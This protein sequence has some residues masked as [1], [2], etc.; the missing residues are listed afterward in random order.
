VPETRGWKSEDARVSGRLLTR[1]ALTGVALYGGLDLAGA[2]GWLECA[3][4]AISRTKPLPVDVENDPA[5][6]WAAELEAMGVGR[7]CF[8]RHYRLL[9]ATDA[10][11]YQ[12]E[13]LGVVVADSAASLAR[14]VAWCGRN[15]V[16]LLVR[17]GG[18]SLAG[19]CV[20]RA[21]VV[22][23]SAA[24][25]RI[26]GL[27]GR[28]VHVEPGVI[29]DDL[30]RWL[31]PRGLF[32]APDPATSAQ[33]TVGGCVGNNAAG[34]R[35]IRYGRTSENVAAL[36]VALTDGRR[37]WLG[38]GAGRRDAA[39]L[40][41]AGRVIEV[42]RDHAD[43]IRRR[44]PK[45]SRRNSG[46][47]LDMV[48]EQLDRGAGT[49]DL[50]L[51]PLIC[52]S[53][54]TLAAV[55]GAKL[56]LREIPRFKGLAIVSFASVGAALDTLSAVLDTQPTAVELLDDAVLRA[57]GGNIECQRY[58]ALVP[59]GSAA[60]AVLYVEYQDAQSAG[61][62]QAGFE[63]LAAALPD[64][65]MATYVQP[66][67]LADA[68][69]LRKAGEPLLHGLSAQRKPVTFIE[70]NAVPAHNLARFV[71]GLRQII[72]RHGTSAAYYA[73]ASVGVLHVRP[74]L[75]LH[76]PSDRA[77]MQAIAVEA[78]ELARQCGGMISGEHGDGRA[79]GPLLEQYFG[80]QLMSAFE[81]IKAI[82]DPAGVL[83]PGMT[84]RPGPVGSIVQNLRVRPGELDLQWPAVQTY[85]DYEDQE[86]LAGAVEMCNGA[87]VCRKS[88]GGTMCPSYRATLDERDSTRG[89]GNALRLAIS[90]QLGDGGQP[91]WDDP[92]TA[93]TLDLCLSC[94]ACKSECPS[95][96][97]M[98]RLKAEYTAQ[99]FTQQGQAPLRN[100]VLGNVRWLNQLGAMV[101]SLA[102]WLTRQRPVRA[103]LNELLGL[104]P[105]RSLPTFGHSLYR[106]FARRRRQGGDEQRGPRVM[107][108]ADCFV[109]YNE[110]HIGQAA[111][112]V[113]EGLGYSVELPPAG[114]CGRA[115]ISN[116]LLEQAIATIDRTL[117]RLRRWI[118]DSDVRAIVVCE[119]SCL[120][121][122]RDEWLSLRLK[123]PKA[124]RQELARKAIMVDEFVQRDWEQHP[125]RPGVKEATPPAVYHGHCHQKAL[126]GQST[127]TDLL[128]RL[129]GQRLTVL[130]SGC[131]GMAGAFGYER[132]HYD[133]SMKIGEQS[134]LAHLRQ[135][136]AQTLIVAPGAS[137]RHQIRDGLQ[138]KAV[139][140]VELLSEALR[141]GEPSAGGA[142]AGS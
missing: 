127:A 2:V 78:A 57:A 50:D 30:N 24:C 124:L 86:S 125:R 7:V 98:A 97:D 20:N 142:A 95:N 74:M 53:A 43:Q 67:Q 14:V 49:A 103:M 73:H 102:N 131:C 92:Q 59:G 80:P 11:N 42:V 75:D 112:G 12:V 104:A 19:Q 85:F 77:A 52:G 88:S 66:R 1:A 55:L 126:W 25:R 65:P 29:L 123:T 113:L 137:C 10:S 87:G 118:E 94:K 133:I 99:R 108:F 139:H 90:G 22:D 69:A 68:W 138:R 115:M 6:R 91:A 63:R 48:L 81:R 120:A 28:T 17:G 76:Q 84:V 134:L 44:Y 130:P 18:T 135:Y 101:P 128:G 117:A 35:S 109:T 3:P 119:P 105:Q 21:L 140:P 100:L 70:D 16:P 71:Q 54:G 27:D 8:D 5:A 41:L 62:V 132:E 15:A 33:A 121:T 114:C 26:I 34:A 122:M 93:R 107:L 40:E 72:A 79:R 38:P 47:A 96:V 58:L 61:Q 45:I 23:H 56:K 51:C 60:Q 116:G 36:E 13:P 37:T 9:Y 31:Q 39:A 141:F 89:R 136:S 106:W 82:F 4:M 46:Y 110:P 83:N 111:I 129:L 32:F 64:Q